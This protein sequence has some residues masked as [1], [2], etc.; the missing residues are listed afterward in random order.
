MSV[1]APLVV[2]RL[3]MSIFIQNE[4]YAQCKYLG[5]YTENYFDNTGDCFNR[6][7][8]ALPWITGKECGWYRD[9]SL[10]ELA[11][12]GNMYIWQR[13]D[14]DQIRGKEIIRYIKRVIPL[15][16]KFQTKVAVST[17]IKV[18]SPV[19]M[20]S[21]VVK[22]EYIEGSPKKGRFEFITSQYPFKLD[23][24]NT[25]VDEYPAGLKTN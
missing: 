9:D 7:N 16:V 23:I 6:F 18:A 17:T 8:Y 14:L 12:Y 15:G 4:T 5:N 19:N 22:Q 24:T 11:Y 3:E 20:F 1:K 13:E 21:A 10:D 2:G 25:E